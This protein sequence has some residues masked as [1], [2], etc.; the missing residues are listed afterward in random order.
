MC[1]EM[2]TIQGAACNWQFLNCSLPDV[3]D[4][5]KFTVYMGNDHLKINKAYREDVH[6][7]KRNSKYF[8]NDD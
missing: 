4:N 2:E 3:F 7:V 1:R 8:I 6:V 5:T